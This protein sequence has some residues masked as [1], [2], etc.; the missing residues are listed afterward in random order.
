MQQFMLL[1]YRLKS[2]CKGLEGL[3]FGCAGIWIAGYRTH[4]GGAGQIREDVYRYQLFN[5]DEGG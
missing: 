1:T 3:I 2:I 5:K 4:Y